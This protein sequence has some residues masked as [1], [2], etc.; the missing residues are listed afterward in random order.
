MLSLSWYSKFL[1]TGNV[2]WRLRKKVNKVRQVT[3]VEKVRKDVTV[4]NF[5]WGQASICW[6]VSPSVPTKSEEPRIGSLSFFAWSQRM[7]KWEKWHGRISREKSWSF[8]NHDTVPKTAI[9]KGFSTLSGFWRKSKS[10]M[11]T[12][13]GG[14]WKFRLSVK[15]PRKPHVR[16]KSGWFLTKFPVRRVE[17]LNYEFS[18]GSISRPALVGRT[19]YCIFW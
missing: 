7:I 19:S 13:Q 10:L 11:V 3:E 18:S 5:S 1:T 6:S 14:K 15:F 16:E 17:I 4:L 8:N 12:F 2:L 9:F